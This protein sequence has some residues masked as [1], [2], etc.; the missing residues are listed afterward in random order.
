DLDDPDC[1]RSILV[2]PPPHCSDQ[3]CQINDINVSAIT[4]ID[5]GTPSVPM[6]D[7]FTFNLFVVGNMVSD[8]F[9]T[10]D[11][12]TPSGD[13]NGFVN[14]GPY[15]ITDGPVTITLTDSED[16]G[17]TNSITVIPPEPCSIDSCII[18]EV[19]VTEAVC[20][21]NGT[22][23]DKTDDRY[24]FNVRV[25]GT[26]TSPQWTIL[27]FPGVRGAYNTE[28]FFG[29]FPASNGGVTFTF[30]DSENMLCEFPITVLPPPECSDCLLE[31]EAGPI[32]LLSCENPETTLDG[33]VNQ[34]GQISFSW[35]GPNGF[36]SD[37]ATPTINEPGRYILTVQDTFDC[38]SIDSVEVIQE[39]D[40][41]IAD[42]GPDINLNC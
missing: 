38:V 12:N 6:D 33:S 18:L 41:P 2:T 10:D 34:T 20:D 36:T 23:D 5:P 42:A 22:P 9:L 26:N 27:E 15:L 32:K 39:A 21:D 35:T 28:F 29:P 13:Y 3:V 25:L 37:I 16:P 11:L 31:A 40:S 4:C 24:S 30:V 1:S 7:M 17:C 14:F 19:L 8:S